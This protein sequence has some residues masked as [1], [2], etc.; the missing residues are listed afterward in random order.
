MSWFL[1]DKG[2]IYDTNISSTVNE[3]KFVTAEWIRKNLENKIYKYM[4]PVSK[5]VYTEKFDN[6]ASNDNNSWNSAIKCKILL[7][8]IQTLIRR[9]LNLVLVTK[10][11]QDI[12]AKDNVPY[13][14]KEAFFVKKVKSTVAWTM[15]LKI[16]KGKKLRVCF[17]IKSYREQVMM[18]K[19][20][21]KL[22]RH[23]DWFSS[24][25]DKT[26]IV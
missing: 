5:K 25:I 9:G 22:K 24:W 23:G 19:M 12:L 1:S 8:L 2:N 18:K 17:S 7:Y 20:F 26:D 6:T 10:R 16:W 21:A 13:C 4:A 11:Y 14:T 3:G 15:W